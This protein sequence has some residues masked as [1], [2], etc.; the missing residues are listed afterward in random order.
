M[1]SVERGRV[2]HVTADYGE[3]SQTFISDAMSELDRRGWEAWLVTRS[4]KNRGQFGFPPDERLIRL[5]K[6]PAG[7]RVAGLIAGRPPL[8]WSDADVASASSRARPSIVHAHFAWLPEDSVR[9]ARAAGAPLVVSFYGA[10]AS[11]WPR[12]PWWETPRRLMTRA[13][14]RYERLFPAIAQAIVP[15]PVVGEQLRALG[16]EGRLDV[17]PSG[18]RLEDFP[19]RA[20]PPRPP[21]R[22]VFVGRLVRRKGLDV[23]LRALSECRRELGDVQLE[24]C[25]DG[26]EREA[27]EHL[28][29]ELGVRE[30]VVFRGALERG[31][32]REAL[33]RAHALVLPSRTMPDGE[34]ETLGVV[35]L[36]A[37]ASGVPVVATRSG[38]IP[39]ALPP[40]W[41]DELV[42]EDSPAELAAAVLAAVTRPDPGARAALGREWVE[43][44]YSWGSLGARL[45]RL[46]LRALG[47]SD[48]L[49]EA[50]PAGTLEG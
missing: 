19:L 41:R 42:P 13:S 50:A 24:V 14:H 18:V 17:L 37:L 3:Y 27:L 15:T 10:D 11:V 8:S 4:L 25:G 49:A 12:F 46:Y 47:A 30:A 9:L 45:E 32:V 35:I 38:G 44:E 36:E 2:L 5:A 43:R 22:L 20:E 23:L 34:I 16:Y 31:Q 7:L 28:A 33:S 26:A 29:A 1:A 21:V 6:R 48:G 40:G 39:S